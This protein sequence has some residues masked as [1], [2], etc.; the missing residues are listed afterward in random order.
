MKKRQ[1]KVNKLRKYQNQT[2]SNLQNPINV[3]IL[4]SVHNQPRWFDFTVHRDSWST[5]LSLSKSRC[6]SN[7]PA[8]TSYT[9]KENHFDQC[10]FNQQNQEEG[11][12]QISRSLNFTVVQMFE[13]LIQV[14]RFTSQ[15]NAE[16][17]E[18]KTDSAFSSRVKSEASIGFRSLKGAFC[19]RPVWRWFK[20]PETCVLGSLGV[21]NWLHVWM[22]ICSG[23]TLPLT[24]WMCRWR[25]IIE[26]FLELTLEFRAVVANSWVWKRSYHCAGPST[27]LPSPMTTNCG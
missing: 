3:S 18:M 25:W 6:Y 1:W 24:L 20:S 15:L 8:I 12:S 16:G 26:N 23:C 13:D 10:L 27:F 19:K 7:L 11:K 17:C 22:V 5:F 21:L 9:H 4:A 14:P 2:C